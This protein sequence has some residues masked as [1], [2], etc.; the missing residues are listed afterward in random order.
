MRCYLS[1]F[2]SKQLEVK[3]INYTSNLSKITKSW[4]F[5]N[6]SCSNVLTLQYK[7]YLQ[8]VTLSLLLYVWK[9]IICEKQFR[10]VKAVRCYLL[11]YLVP[12]RTVLF[13]THDTLYNQW[14]FTQLSERNSWRKKHN[15]NKDQSFQDELTVIIKDH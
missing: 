10:E 3:A 14:R 11:L 9:T 13:S 12:L 5:G 15:Q 6:L 1:W 7:W 4:F 2:Y 8:F